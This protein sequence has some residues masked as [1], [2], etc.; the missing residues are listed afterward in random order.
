[1][2]FNAMLKSCLPFSSL[3]Q[4][5]RFPCTE[6]ARRSFEFKW[7]CATALLWPAWDDSSSWSQGCSTSHQL[8]S[9]QQRSVGSAQLP[10]DGSWRSQRCH[11]TAIR[12]DIWV[13]STLQAHLV[14]NGWH[15]CGHGLGNE[16]GCSHPTLQAQVM[17][18]SCGRYQLHLLTQRSFSPLRSR[19][20][21]LPIVCCT[22][23]CTDTVSSS[24]WAELMQLPGA[25]SQA[26][27]QNASY[28]ALTDYEISHVLQKSWGWDP[29]AL[30]GWKEEL[31]TRR[32]PRGCP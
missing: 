18:G 5:Y 24:R 29:Y 31:S 6:L 9:I 26:W 23:Q 30:P 19:V 16:W 8:G 20:R 11:S 17:W 10:A 32:A 1:M 14:V 2:Q 22:D 12:K 21:G 27:Q 28:Q 3:L 4:Q 13:F 7:L 25:S 15:R